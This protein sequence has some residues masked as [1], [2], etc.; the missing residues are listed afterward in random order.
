M[1]AYVVTA[2]MHWGRRPVRF[3]RFAVKFV[4][5][6][7]GDFVEVILLRRHYTV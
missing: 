1:S 5:Q 4:M 2:I 3:V 6:N 7:D